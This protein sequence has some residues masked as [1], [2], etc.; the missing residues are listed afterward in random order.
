MH[1]P[2][3]VLDLDIVRARHAALRRSLPGA[4]IYYAVKANPSREVVATLAGLDTKFDVASRGEIAL[5]RSLDIPAARLSFGNTIKHERVRMNRRRACGSSARRLSRQISQS[6]FPEKR[7]HR[8]P[9][10]RSQR[11]FVTQLASGRHRGGALRAPENQKEKNSKPWLRLPRPGIQG[12]ASL[13]LRG[14]YSAGSGSHL[15][16][17]VMTE[18]HLADHWQVSPKTL[19]RWRS[20]NEGPV[21]YK[22]F[23]HVRYHE[24]DIIDFERRS[25][26]HLMT[27]LGINREFKPSDAEDGEELDAEGNHYLAAKEI[28]DAASLPIYLFRD[29][30][31]RRRK[32]VPHLMLVGNLRFSLP[33][34]LEWEMANSVQGNAA[35]AVVEEAEV[36]AEAP[37]PA[38][39]W[40]EIVREQ[41]GERFDSAP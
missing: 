41:D 6:P 19:R 17:P 22:L 39:R 36:P 26:Q 35:A 11:V 10:G 5:C 32:R 18:K 13:K 7:R 28:A 30:A 37:V 4:E 21:W 3:I 29:Q 1:R 24:A 2:R 14:I 27:L 34:I 38:K 9:A 15:H 40:Y 33:A 8:H 31:E 23:H 16:Y 12:N 20:D 25:A